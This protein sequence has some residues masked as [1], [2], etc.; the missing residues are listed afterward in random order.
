MGLDVLQVFRF[1]AVD[2]AGQVEVVVVPGDLLVAHEARI[3]GQLQLAGEHIDDLVDVAL[4]QPVLG[5]V[6]DE[7]LAGI[8]QED[9]LAAAGRALVDHQDAGGDA[10]AIE[11]VGR[12][13]YDPLDQTPLDQ[14]LADLGFGVAAEQ[15]AMGKDATAS[16]GALER[17]HDVQQ[18]GIVALLGRWDAKTLE[19]PIGILGRIEPGAP[20][21]VGERWIGHHVIELLELLALLEFGIGQ[22][23]ALPDD[24]C[25]VAVQ[26]H[27]HPRQAAGGR[28][29]LLPVER[30]RPARLG[31]DLQQQRP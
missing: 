24:C 30:H 14:V 13:A 9:P 27:V 17:A 4:P 21:L 25:G 26:D 1:A 16:A 10:G 29:L 6:L 23:V 19:A 11:E 12:Q 22:G 2:V 3:A 15:H 28:I 18:V 5:A 31:G 20:A 8:H 7:T